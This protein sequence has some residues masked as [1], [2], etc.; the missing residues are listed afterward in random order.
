VIV[1]LV[2]ACVVLWAWSRRRRARQV[3]AKVQQAV[4]DALEQQSD[5]HAEAGERP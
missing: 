4:A 3:D 5:P 2:A 1:V